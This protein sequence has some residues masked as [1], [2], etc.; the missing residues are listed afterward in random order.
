MIINYVILF[1]SNPLCQSKYFIEPSDEHIDFK[2]TRRGYGFYPSGDS[3]TINNIEDPFPHIAENSKLSALHS[4]LMISFKGNNSEP[5]GHEF[6]Q[7]NNNIEETEYP[8]EFQ[9]YNHLY[10]MEETLDSNVQKNSFSIN[11]AK[12]I[13]EMP[14]QHNKASVKTTSIAFPISPW[15]QSITLED[16]VQRFLAQA[17]ELAHQNTKIASEKLH[18]AEMFD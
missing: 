11:S 9:N 14:E 2:N 10:S 17:A 15:N 12:N 13:V 18:P 16:K 3:M 8:F 5:Y 4:N 6:D 7:E 1:R